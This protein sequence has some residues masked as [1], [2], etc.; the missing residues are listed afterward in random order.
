MLDVNIIL[1]KNK[2]SV[3]KITVVSIGHYRGKRLLPEYRNCGLKNRVKDT[4]RSVST[5]GQSLY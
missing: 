1:M 5:Q 2:V 3:F 4:W